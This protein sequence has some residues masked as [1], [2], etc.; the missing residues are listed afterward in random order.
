MAKSP[1]LPNVAANGDKLI[2]DA[3]KAQAEAKSVGTFFF[4]RVGGKAY[5]CGIRA[6][7]FDK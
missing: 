5:V 7:R 1:L 3:R 4:K 6:P 2:A